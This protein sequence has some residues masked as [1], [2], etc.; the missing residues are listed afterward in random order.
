L[1]A[2]ECAT[3]D[4][5]PETISRSKLAAICSHS[6]HRRFAQALRQKRM[7]VKLDGWRWI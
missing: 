5:A 2:P 3:H 4:A 1:A 6:L 7:M